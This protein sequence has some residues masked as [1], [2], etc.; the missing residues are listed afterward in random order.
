[1]QDFKKTF[2][3]SKGFSVNLVKINETQFLIKLKGKIKRKRSLS[4]RCDPKH[5]PCITQ[6]NSQNNLVNQV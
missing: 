2:H 3:N 1:M 4:S 5:I 6:L